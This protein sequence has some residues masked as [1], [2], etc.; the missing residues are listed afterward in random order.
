MFRDTAW[1]RFL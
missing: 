1:Y